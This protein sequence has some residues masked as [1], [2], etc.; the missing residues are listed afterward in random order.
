MM[1]EKD[2]IIAIITNFFP[3]NGEGSSKYNVEISVGLTSRNHY[4]LE[5]TIITF[6]SIKTT[7]NALQ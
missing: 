7:S 4:R 5:P 6:M 2:C 1:H 3:K